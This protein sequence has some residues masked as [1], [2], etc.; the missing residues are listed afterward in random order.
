MTWNW[1]TGVF[2]GANFHYVLSSIARRFFY[3]AEV[4]ILGKLSREGKVVPDIDVAFRF[5]TKLTMLGATNGFGWVKILNWSFLC[6]TSTKFYPQPSPPPGPWWIFI[7]GIV[8]RLDRLLADN[9]SLLC[10]S[11]QFYN[12]R[13]LALSPRNEIQLLSSFFPI[14]K[15]EL[16]IWFFVEESVASQRDS[17][18]VAVVT[19]HAGS[20]GGQQVKS[21]S[22]KD[23]KFLTVL[24]L[25]LPPQNEKQLVWGG[26]RL[27][28][29]VQHKGFCSSFRA[30]LTRLLKNCIQDEPE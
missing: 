13:V 2:L 28:I 27:G 15:T 1:A 24:V 4:S 16:F 11:V 21:F 22:Y 17:S 10:I 12:Y 5:G 19:V 26:L 7:S 29:Q 3:N 25:P 14:F 6:S 23:F 30:S 18:M 9:W 20:Y 8:C